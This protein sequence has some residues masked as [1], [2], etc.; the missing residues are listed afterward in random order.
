MILDSSRDYC[1]FLIGGTGRVVL[2]TSCSCGSMAGIGSGANVRGHVLSAGMGRTA[3]ELETVIGISCGH[4][5]G[6]LGCLV[7]CSANES[8]V[9]I[10][11]GE[12][13]AAGG[14]VLN[15]ATG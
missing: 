9:D 11:I 8:H 14:M 15:D 13:G 5:C 6:S 2:V 12:P 7:C 4:G 1:C 10:A 3:A